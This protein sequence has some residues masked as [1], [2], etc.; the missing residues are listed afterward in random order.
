MPPVSHTLRIPAD[1]SQ[2]AVARQFISGVCANLGLSVSVSDPLELAVDELFCNI[3]VHGY[4]GQPGMIEIEIEQVEDALRVHLRD[5]APQFDPTRLPN[6]DITLPFDQRPAGGMGV[7]LAR[8]NVDHI[9]YEQAA[10]GGNHLTL[11]KKTPAA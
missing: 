4:G 7:Y 1:A 10:D 5:Q 9:A 11:T 2:L 3:I 6:P 8:R